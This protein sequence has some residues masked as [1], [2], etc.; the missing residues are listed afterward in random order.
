[1]FFAIFLVKVVHPLGHFEMFHFYEDTLSVGL[2][3]RTVEWRDWLTESLT[4]WLTEVSRVSESSEWVKWVKWVEW[5]GWCV[6]EWVIIHFIFLSCHVFT[7][8]ITHLTHSLTHT[9]GTVDFLFVFYLFIFFLCVLFVCVCVFL[10]VLVC[11]GV[12]VCVCCVA[13]HAFFPFQLCCISVINTSYCLKEILLSF[14]FLV[15]STCCTFLC[16]FRLINCFVCDC[17]F[18]FHKLKRV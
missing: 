7:T 17:V 12:S 2:N 3:D 9:A 10:C 5:G 16:L 1:M 11:F 13:L 15:S 14:S 8:F 4:D 18:S 6:V